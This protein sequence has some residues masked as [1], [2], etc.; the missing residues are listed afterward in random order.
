MP[1]QLGSDTWSMTDPFSWVVWCLAIICVPLY[2]VIMGFADYAFSGYA[3]W[4][5]LIGFVIRIALSENDSNLPEHKWKYQKIFLM[6]WIS[7]VFILVVAYAGNL[8]AMLTRPTLPERLRN[9]EDLL[10]QDD[11]S[12]VMEKETIQEFHFRAANSGTTLNRLYEFS[13]MMTPLTT[14]ERIRYGCYKGMCKYYHHIFLSSS[15][16]GKSLVT[17]ALCISSKFCEIQFG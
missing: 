17:Q 4:E 14:T 8:T 12:L 13:T 11:I 1:L 2:V 9:A 5:A 16:R 3:D 10:S 7:P 6:F 15:V